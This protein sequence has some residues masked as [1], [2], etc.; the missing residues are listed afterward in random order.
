MHFIEGSSIEGLLARWSSRAQEFRRLRVSV[1]GATLIEELMADVQ[2]VHDS[3]SAEHLTLQE[4]S[5]LGGYSDDYLQRLVA[6]G[7]I[8]NV[9]R[10]GRPRIRRSDV[11]IKP[12]HSLRSEPQFDH[13]DS[14]RRMALAV[15]NPQGEMT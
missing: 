8:R 1:D 14:R 2:V 9:G 5:K 3:R 11:P 4:A 15:I 10:R 6:T 13:L 12:G 7:A